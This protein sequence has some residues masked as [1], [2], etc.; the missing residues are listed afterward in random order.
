MFLTPRREKVIQVSQTWLFVGWM[1]ACPPSQE[2]HHHQDFDTILG[3]FGE[4]L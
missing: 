2:A 4:S 3:E 1:M